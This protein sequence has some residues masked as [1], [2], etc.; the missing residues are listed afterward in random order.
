MKVYAN[1]G[2]RAVLIE[3]ERLRVKNALVSINLFPVIFTVKV[4]RPLTFS[5]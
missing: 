3:I 5:V 2:V 1:I 4:A